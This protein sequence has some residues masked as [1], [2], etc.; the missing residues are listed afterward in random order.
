MEQ[1]VNKSDLGAELDALHT[2]AVTHAHAVAADDE[3]WRSDRPA[4][5]HS[6][7]LFDQAAAIVRKVDE[8]RAVVTT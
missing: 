3:S 5:R 7:H 6:P 4:G 2:L 8:L 1:K